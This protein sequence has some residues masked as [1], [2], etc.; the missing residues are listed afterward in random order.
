M[1][2]KT[3]TTKW[4]VN[5]S[6]TTNMLHWIDTSTQTLADSTLVDQRPHFVEFNPWLGLAR[7]RRK[8]AAP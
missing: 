4:A 5:T 3:R 1:A 8:S 2:V 6:E 7:L